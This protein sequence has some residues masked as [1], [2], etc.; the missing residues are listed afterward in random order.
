M[1]ILLVHPADSVESGPW[2]GSDWGLIVDLGWSGRHSY[3]HQSGRFE[4]RVVSL[5]DLLNHAEHR[6]Q[7]HDLLEIGR[8]QLV[9]SESVDW[10]DA[11]SAFVY[12]PVEQVMLSSV[13][14]GEIPENAEIFATR[15]HFVTQAVSLLLGRTISY[16]SSTLEASFGEATRQYWKKVSA[17]RPAEVAE[18]A[19]DKWDTGYGL[20]RHVSR[21]AS[22]SDEPL[23]LLPSAYVN[24]S[25]AQVAYAEMLPHRRFMLVV[26]RPNGRRLKVPANV[27][28]RS[29]ASY[30]PGLSPSSK[31][32]CTSLL[33]KWKTLQKTFAF[34][35][36]LCLA[37][38]LGIFDGMTSFLRNGLR[39]RDA[40]REVILREPITAVL[41]ADEHN[42]FTRLPVIL[43]KSREV[44]TI[45]CDHGALNMTLGIRPMCSKTYL[46]SGEMARDYVETWCQ[47]PAEEIAVGGPR[48]I[49]GLAASSTDK[50]RDW[51]VF[52]SEQ[53][54]ISSARAETIYSELLPELCM[55]A[56]QTGRKVIVK[57]HPF[58]SL[59]VRKA[60]V[61]RTVRS[62]DRSLVELRKGP[63]TPD[64]F[65]RAWFTVT[66]ESSV[67]VESTMNGVP[68]F[69]CGWFDASWYEYARQYEKFSAGYWL[70]SPMSVRQIPQL[71]EQ[72]KITDATRGALHTSI[73]PERLEA[74]LFG[75]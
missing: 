27:E 53:C 51:I 64:L 72:I 29:L 31:D 69:L 54:E 66:V 43:A 56:R 18:I 65:D 7:L 75:I 24:V 70:D 42:P 11:F 73:R 58:E 61:D 30:A 33:Q 36:V 17:L 35:R 40:W 62:E 50:L 47:V 59:R 8:H 21:R 44:R 55:L 25:R 6:S 32:E 13:L 57:L 60:M 3:S 46:V 41:S 26:T 10:W 37:T 23:V 4:C 38:Q 12:Q 67:A 39:V 16:L 2:A 63:M 19:F 48:K 52:F 5:C 1:K 34:D 28:V 45:L 74:L 20:R 14:A 68:C 71:L 9:D 15:S 22:T 49:D